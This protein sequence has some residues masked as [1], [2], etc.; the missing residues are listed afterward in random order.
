MALDQTVQLADAVATAVAEQRRLRIVGHDSKQQWQ[1]PNA[2][3]EPLDLTHHSGVIDYQPT[4]LVITA[5]G[6]T[7]LAELNQ[8]LA[9]QGQKLASEPPLLGAEPNQGTLAGAVACGF[10]GPARPWGGSLRD[11]VLGVE[12]LNG[13][14]E[15]LQFGGQVMKNV[16]GYD[17]S[18]LQAGAWGSLGVLLN[19]SLRVQPL[20]AC[21]QT[22]QFSMSAVAANQFARTLA[23]KNLPLTADCWVDGRYY[24]RLAGHAKTV[25][26]ALEFVGGSAIGDDAAAEF[27]QQLRDQQQNFFQSAQAPQLWR[28]IT[29]PAAPLPDMAEQQMLLEWQGGLRWL[30]HNDADFVHSYA[31][32]VAG[33]CWAV[34]DCQPIDPQ[35]AW[36]MQRLKRA[37]DPAAIFAS[38]LDFERA[39]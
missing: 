22:V 12:L 10:S 29:P 32:Q 39:N 27:W 26:Q 30:R 31:R 11:A 33:W 8:V 15:V 4:E 17:A 37:F 25:A 1:W 6:G 18:R 7:A 9:E 19:V 36:L 24:L 2:D 3:A 34:G 16:A 35:Q 20:E 5:R 23:Q 14:G 13:R 38:A 28:L 21:T